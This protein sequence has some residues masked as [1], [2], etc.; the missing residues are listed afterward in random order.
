MSG[1]DHLSVLED[2]IRVVQVDSPVHTVDTAALVP[3]ESAAD[4]AVFV[5]DSGA[6]ADL[7]CRIFAAIAYLSPISNPMLPVDFQA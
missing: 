6:S 2:G 7:V 5:V 4:N 3:L 1:V